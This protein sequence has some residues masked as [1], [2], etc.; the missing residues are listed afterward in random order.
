M[1]ANKWK[2]QSYIT[3]LLLLLNSQLM[4]KTIIILPNYFYKTLLIGWC[5][6]CFFTNKKIQ[7]AKNFIIILLLI[8][9]C[10]SVYIVGS[11]YNLGDAV[12]DL[13]FVSIIF[14]AYSY[15]L[16]K[17]NKFDIFCESYSDI[18]QIICLV[19]LFFWLFGSVLNLLPYKSI[20]YSWLKGV[21]NSKTYLY[22]Y[23]ENAIQNQKI[24]GMYIPHNCGI[25]VEATIYS[26]FLIY[27]I[28]IEWFKNRGINKN[29]LIFLVIT[30]I[31]TFSTKALVVLIA[32]FTIKYV[33]DNRKNKRPII[34]LI[35]F[36]LSLLLIFI[37]AFSI[38]QIII[39]KSTTASYAVRMDDLR[40]AL[41]TWKNHLIFG[42]GY[43]NDESIIANTTTPWLRE[44]VTGVTMGVTVLLAEGGIVLFSYYILAVYLAYNSPIIQKK[45]MDFIFFAVMIFINLLSSNAAFSMPILFMISSC[46]AVFAAAPPKR[47]VLHNKK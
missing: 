32:T 21:Y 28:G 36:A 23:F 6:V 1:T 9:I 45:K 41:I 22:L 17:R 27:A 5:L 13:L 4:L 11:R 30:L 20:T 46:Y 39:D 35:K 25:F 37:A 44:E 14:Y 34:R 33:F 7:G 38:Y 42:S 29:R 26:N 24:F 19:S 16:I 3:I 10:L 12:R 2:I 31:S 8:S 47:A 18:M 15:S 40:A 43:G